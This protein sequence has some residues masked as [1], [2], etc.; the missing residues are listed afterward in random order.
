M[1]KFAVYAGLYLGAQ[2]MS[3]Q[4]PVSY[5]GEQNV[6]DVRGNEILVRSFDNR[7]EGVKGSPF[8]FNEWAT[9][10]IIAEGTAYEFQSKL[11]ANESKIIYSIHNRLFEK[12]LTEVDSVFLL[13]GSLKVGITYINKYKTALT[14]PGRDVLYKIVLVKQLR[15]ADYQG[16]YNQNRPYDEYITEVQL[17]ACKDLDACQR[18]K[19][20]DYQDFGVSRKDVKDI[21]IEGK[22][23]QFTM[24]VKK[25][26][27][28]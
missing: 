26:E 10:R 15:K 4:K 16:A 17:F 2:L 22:L 5:Q 28:L 19:N 3:A 11:E 6:Q 18:M 23:Q 20:K 8:L 7:Y 13:T 24:L 21:L 9:F 12:D 1:K 25:I 14:I 27:G